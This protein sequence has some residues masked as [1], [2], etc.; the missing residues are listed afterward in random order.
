MHLLAELKGLN[1]SS[2]GRPLQQATAVVSEILLK[3]GGKQSQRG[4]AP[5]ALSQLAIRHTKRRKARAVMLPC[6]SRCVDLHLI[7]DTDKQINI[8]TFLGWFVC[9][10]CLSGRPSY[11]WTKRDASS[12]FKGDRYP[13]STDRRTNIVQLVIKKI[14]K[15][16]PQDVTL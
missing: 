6:C 15:I 7:Q 5:A 14:I 13:E 11:G 3:C 4:R 1:I 8:C 9:P 2:Y 16:W 10:L 12:K